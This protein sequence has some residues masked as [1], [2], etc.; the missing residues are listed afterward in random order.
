MH[1]LK[2]INLGT[3]TII[4]KAMKPISHKSTP[5]KDIKKFL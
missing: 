3:D 5:N 4:D 1:L 2:I